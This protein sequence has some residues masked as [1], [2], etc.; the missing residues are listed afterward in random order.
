MS[1]SE[2]VTE[3]SPRSGRITTRLG[4]RLGVWWTAI[5]PKTLVAGI[6]PVSVGSALAWRVE[7]L[8]L[9]LAIACL[10]VA[11]GVQIGANLTNDYFDF[12]KGADTVDRVGPVRVTSAGLASPRRVLAGAVV[13]LAVAAV[14]GIPIVWVGGWP[15]L[16]VGVVAIASAV[17]YTAGPAPIAY[18]GLGDLFVLVFFGLVATVGTFAVQT[19]EYTS[20]SILMGLAIG[21]F[22]MALLAVNNQRDIVT[23]QVVG[24]RTLAVRIGRTGTKIQITSLATTGLALPVAGVA[25]GDLALPTLIVLCAAPFLVTPLR[26]VWADDGSNPASLIPALAGIARS[27][28]VFGILATV[29]VAL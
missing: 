8:R 9:G 28:L 24:K 21:C 10:I 7:S 26:A 20:A 14:A 23:D 19:G 15:Y 3:T 25:L 27:Q 12:R 13:S 5:R 11:I 18:L 1:A 4:I 22:A 17:L 29:G 6:V 16:V 2:S